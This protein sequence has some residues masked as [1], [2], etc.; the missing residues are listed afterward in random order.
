MSSN[1]FSCLSNLSLIFA[2]AGRCLGDFSGWEKIKKSDWGVCLFLMFFYQQTAEGAEE[3]QYHSRE[4]FTVRTSISEHFSVRRKRQQ[5]S[6]KNTWR[7]IKGKKRKKKEPLTSTWSRLMRAGRCR[8]STWR[9]LWR[10]WHPG[11]E[12]QHRAT[13]KG[14]SINGR[15]SIM[16]IRWCH[17][18]KKG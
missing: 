16:L 17:S 2:L 12:N 6:T 9:Y 1:E 14:K 11:S 10:W 18:V 4:V 8:C 3:R 13:K 15:L 5:E 7:E